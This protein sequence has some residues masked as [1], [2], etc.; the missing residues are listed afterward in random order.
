MNIEYRFSQWS[1]YGQNFPFEFTERSRFFLFHCQ[2]S[3]IHEGRSE[4]RYLKSE[5]FLEC[6]GQVPA[7][8]EDCKRDGAQGE[9]LQ[10]ILRI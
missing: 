8:V 3:S 1:V 10:L 9:I 6:F 7:H 4:S 2:A 5:Q